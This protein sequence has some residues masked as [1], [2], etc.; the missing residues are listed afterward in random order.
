MQAGL[1]PEFDIGL[2]AW[3]LRETQLSFLRAA[4]IES[5]DV[6]IQIPTTRTIMNIARPLNPVPRYALV[7]GF[8]TLMSL[9]SLADAQ[10][11]KDRETCQAN[12]RRIHEAIQQYRRDHKD[13]PNW[14]SDL[15]PQY[16][17]ETNAIVCPV[18]LRTG[19]I[20][21]FQNVADPIN[22]SAYVY[23]FCPAPMGSIWGGG[24]RTMREW[25]RRQM[26][27]VGGDV[28]I[29]R[30]H[31]HSPVLNLAFSGRI[32]QSPLEWETLFNDVV[33]FQAWSPDR[34]FSDFGAPA[35]VGAQTQPAE[36][37]KAD[38]PA[39][40]P[41]RDPASTPKQ[42]DLGPFYNASLTNNWHGRREG[43][44]LAEL[45]R[46]LQTLDGTRFDIRGVVQ[47]T[48]DPSLLGREYP[49]AKKG[50]PINQK[51]A[52]IHFLHATAFGMADGTEIANYTVHYASG[53]MQEIPVID[54]KDLQ[55][56][57][58]Y[59]QLLKP[60]G[61]PKIVWQ[62]MNNAV[63]DWGNGVKVGLFKSSWAN[64][65]PDDT[66]SSLDFTARRAAPFLIAITVE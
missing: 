63:K 8:V 26:G 39:G 27:I 12:L 33:D 34:L 57:W 18:T 44:D 6:K 48:S 2:L 28:P 5:G 29:V 31:L 64:P 62:G 60:D 38:Q 40:I 37:V 24:E 58:L 20:Q 15:V 56:W 36:L 54:G 1:V 43:N 52:T 47:L 13:I 4:F 61:G 42:I 3:K 22:N 11:D 7:V 65:A 25:K 66:I 51:V 21:L 14:L 59:P 45:P 10:A 17:K 41:A 53:R 23:E 30:C 55:D 19:Q 32:Y 50:I 9:S 35:S 49:T 16:I 46:G